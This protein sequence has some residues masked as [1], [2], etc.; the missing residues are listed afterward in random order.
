MPEVERLWQ[1]RTI[2]RRSASGLERRE[3]PSN[4]QSYV[5]DT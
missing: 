2:E 4:A 3:A 1:R 5:T